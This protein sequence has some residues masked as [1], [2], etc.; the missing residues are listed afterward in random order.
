MFSSPEEIEETWRSCQNSAQHLWGEHFDQVVQQ[1][2]GQGLPN[3]HNWRPDV[4]SFASHAVMRVLENSRFMIAVAY[5]SIT[6]YYW[7]GCYMLVRQWR[8]VESCS[9]IEYLS[10]WFSLNALWQY[11]LNTGH[12]L[13]LFLLRGRP[14]LFVRAIKVIPCTG[15]APCESCGSW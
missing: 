2:W 14:P 1:V 4:S 7:A 9:I 12:R 8:V 15:G 10:L 13:W 11:V 3:W 5:C 6:A